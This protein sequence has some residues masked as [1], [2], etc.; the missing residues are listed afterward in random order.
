MFANTHHGILY[1]RLTLCQE[2]YITESGSHVKIGPCCPVI[3]PTPT[4]APSPISTDDET[5]T[6]VETDPTQEETDTESTTPTE[7]ETESE[8]TESPTPPE[9]D[10]EV[11]NQTGIDVAQESCTVLYLSVRRGGT[12]P[13]KQTQKARIC[14]WFILLF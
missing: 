14:E 2:T 11:T 13:Y 6:E 5:E 4:E 9:T 10:S 1:E 3:A 12:Y 7:P 8:D